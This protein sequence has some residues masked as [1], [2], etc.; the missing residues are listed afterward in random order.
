M[1]VSTHRR[2]KTNIGCDG[3]ELCED[4]MT[5][6]LALTSGEHQLVRHWVQ[7][8]PLGESLSSQC[9]AATWQEH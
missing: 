4:I 5:D 9:A 3:E 7:S 8:A 2:R 1:S 6:E